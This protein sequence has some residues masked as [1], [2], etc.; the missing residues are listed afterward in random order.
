MPRTKIKRG[1]Q[2]ECKFS[3]TTEPKSPFSSFHAIAIVHE[4]AHWANMVIC[5]YRSINIC[6]HASANTRNT[7][8]SPTYFRS[9]NKI[10]KPIL[11]PVSLSLPPSVPLLPLPLPSLQPSPTAGAELIS[12]APSLFSPS[13]PS[14]LFA[15]PSAASCLPS[16][17]SSFFALS[18]SFACD[19]EY[20]FSDLL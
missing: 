3:P 12:N 6:R 16:S 17:P 8:P 11:F 15:T 7:L 4:C 13:H 18:A 9:I 5:F 14:K 1:P 2:S 19:D 10:S 20:K